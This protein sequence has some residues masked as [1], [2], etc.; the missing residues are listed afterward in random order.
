MLKFITAIKK[1]IGHG[2]LKPSGIILHATAGKSGQSSVEWLWKINLGY[3][4]IIER[5]GTIIVGVPRGEVADHA[6]ISKGWAGKGCNSYTIG[7][8]FANMDNGELLTKA[9]ILACDELCAEL[10]RKEPGLKFVS[11]HKYVSP[12]RKTDPVV[13]SFSDSEY[14]GMKVWKK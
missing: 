10:V 14:C 2:N 9:Q 11:C 8:S 4:Y 13:W 6:G 12:G 7:V 5:D 3:H 1:L